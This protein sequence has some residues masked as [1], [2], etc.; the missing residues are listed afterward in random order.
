VR[1]VRGVYVPGEKVQHAVG[2][3]GGREGG[4]QGRS[5]V[6]LPFPHP[7]DISG[8]TL[9]TSLLLTNTPHYSKE[10]VQGDTYK[11]IKKFRFY[12]KCL[13]CSREITFITDPEKMDYAM[14]V[15]REGG[16]MGRDVRGS[17]RGAARRDES[18]RT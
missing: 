9:Q 8:I 2:G 17:S 10:D 18:A 11:G 7:E 5:E 13:T 3:E 12:M 15:R 1:D 4:R 6:L 16:R 14:E